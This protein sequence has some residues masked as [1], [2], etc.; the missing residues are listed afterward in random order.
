[1][2]FVDGAVVDVGDTGV[3]DCHDLV[4][5]VLTGVDEVGVGTERR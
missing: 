1:V 4:I 3:D 5:V 2:V